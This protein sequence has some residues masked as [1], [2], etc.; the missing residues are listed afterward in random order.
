MSI[1]L[2]PDLG[3]NLQ[4]KYCYEKGTRPWKQE[5]DIEAIKKT[6]YF[7]Y[8]NESMDSICA[9]GGEALTLP[10]PT[11]EELLKMAYEKTGCS[12]IQTN[13][14]LID[15]DHIRMFK[16]YKT[17]VGISIDGRWP[18]NELRWAGSTE[19]TK[20]M[21]ERTIA[22]I[23]KLVDNKIF[24]GLIVVIHKANGTKERLPTLKD[25][26]QEMYDIGIKWG[27]L[28][29]VIS[30]EYQLSPQ[31]AKHAYLDLC[32][33]TFADPERHYQPFRDMVDNLLG[34]G[35]GTCVFT[36][37]DY[38]HTEAGRV[39]LGDGSRSCCLKTAMDGN[40]PF[41]WDDKT[42]QT[43][44][45][46][47]NKIPKEAGGC[48]GCRY[49]RVCYGFCPAETP[50]GDW[51]GKAIFCDAYHACFEFIEKRIKS[52]FPNII[53]VPDTKY[54]DE[55]KDYL[56]RRG[57]RWSRKA[58]SSM[59]Y[60]FVKN[61]SSWK[62]NIQPTVSCGNKKQD[63]QSTNPQSI[64]GKPGYFHADH[65]DANNNRPCKHN[66]KHEPVPVPGKPGYTHI[67]YSDKNMGRK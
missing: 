57:N 2:K 13:G 3:C 30:N 10:K 24:P 12:S 60:E 17:G 15:D 56:E 5:I 51:R 8:D 16:Q 66:K 9:H 6:T 48:K 11:L 44:Y 29:F 50:N 46:I 22:N 32:E 38:Y 28:N 27:R 63:R 54:E 39:V 41:L 34:L 61:P 19:K 58:F 4:C 33:Y 59:D 23:Y 37:C 67:D 26:L 21:T 40:R 7:I 42:Y 45:E 55:D 64:P 20:E 52:L 43:R 14:T 53:L 35:M 18:L 31:E 49:W 65:A 25:F 36:K 47:L 1:L 62:N